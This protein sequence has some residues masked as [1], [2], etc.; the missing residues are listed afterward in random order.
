MGFVAR[1]R[2]RGVGTVEATIEEVARKAGVSTATVSRSLRGMAGVS[3]RTAERVR[4]VAEQIGYSV[5]PFASRLAS[6]RAGT[7]AVILPYL[8]RWFFGEILGAAEPVF[9]ETGLDLLLYHVGDIEARRDYFSFHLLRQRVDGVLLVT[10]ALLPSESDALRALRVPVCTVGVE[11]AGFHSV[12]I[13]D[14]AAAARAVQHL[15]NLGH[16]RIALISGDTDDTT[17]FTV[18]RDRRT[19]YRAALEAGGLPADPS[20]EVRGDFTAAGGR[21]AV[22]ELFA[23]QDPLTAIFAESDETAFGALGSLTR[24]GLKVPPDISLVGFDDHPLAEILD[25]TTISQS[26]VDQGRAVARQLVA[27]LGGAAEQSEPWQL[28]L[29]TALV[30]RGTTRVASS[31]SGATPRAPAADEAKPQA[32]RAMAAGGPRSRSSSS[33]PAKLS[34]WAATAKR[35]APVV[36]TSKSKTERKRQTYE[37]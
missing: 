11:V 34:R 17:M 5:S 25:L 27:A 14:I 21:R 16:R 9:Q 36:I 35:D 4:N 26:V 30:V 10:L 15:I 31:S 32:T 12:N 20:V 3:A 24:M 8:D 22:A 19:G 1:A 23:W 7:V 33:R 2:R 6:G 13:D 18:P 28:R 37:Q 29:P